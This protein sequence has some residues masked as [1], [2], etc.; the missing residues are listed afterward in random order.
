MKFKKL[1]SL[2][3]S[4]TILLLTVNLSAYCDYE[5]S[6]ES[7][8]DFSSELELFLSD[9]SQY[10][11][12]AETPD[13]IENGDYILLNTN[14]LIVSTNSN[15]S[16]VNTLGA[17]DELC[18]YN[19]WHILQ[20]SN[21]AAVT[22]AFEYFSKQND[23]NYVEYDKILDSYST[24]TYSSD[25]QSLSWGSTTVKAI[26][27]IGSLEKSNIP[28]ATV[29]VAV[30]DTGVDISHPFFVD[31][32]GIS[33]VIANTKERDNTADPNIEKYYHGT[34]VAGIIV[35][36]T[37]SNVKIKSYNSFYSNQTFSSVSTVA[38]EIDRATRDNVDV[39]N[40]SQG[41]PNRSD[42]IEEAVNNAIGK[43]IVVVA[44]AGNQGDEA[45]KYHSGNIEQLIT[46]ASTTSSDKPRSDSNYGSVVDISAPGSNIKSTMPNNSYAKKSGTSMA[47]PFVSAAAAILKSTD[48]N[49][50]P[51][52]ICEIITKSAYIPTSWDS[53]K[54]GAG[55]V[56]FKNMLAYITMPAPKIT[57]SSDGKISIT[58]QAG[59][60]AIYYYTTNGT[61]PTTKS[62]K[63]SK[64]FP[65]P[66]GAVSIKAIA[67]V[68]GI[69]KSSV[70]TYPIQVRT[71]LTVYYKAST[72]L[73]L[74]DD[75]YNTNYFVYD[76]DIVSVKDGR[77]TGLKIGKT[78]VT[79]SMN[80]NRIYRYDIT[81]DFAWWQFFHRIIY[82]VFGILI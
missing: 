69:I 29:T 81:V 38:S 59:K 27:A 40:I 82:K 28:C 32:T 17:V 25:S 6:S 21:E 19:N 51:E 31:G 26:D 61:T 76:N 55:I 70:A 73:P 79:V 24:S 72:T 1:L 66:Y 52:R 8:L 33:R 58:S 56:N 15:T 11:S 75:A 18:G 63:Y 48:K 36:N 64:S 23:I 37:P 9:N 80:G 62:T 65:V 2:V 34:H 45:G 50:S 13:S 54:Y 22:A 5:D 4:L 44:S 47:T 20:Y 43:G 53:A 7:T 46:V 57:L 39:I 16:L 10:S 74:P 41:G 49:L 35:D 12:I 71:S 60:N 68:D 42:M 78:T 3:F 67:Y 77:V 30:I 14:R